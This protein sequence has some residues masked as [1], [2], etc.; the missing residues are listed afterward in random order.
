M[1]AKI[2]FNEN[3]MCQKT[4]LTWNTTA[5]GFEASRDNSGISDNT[6][7]HT[8]PETLYNQKNTPTL[9]LLGVKIYVTTVILPPSMKSEI[10]PFLRNRL[11]LFFI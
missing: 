4:K 5:D 1:K 2:E 3:C 11:L 9:R 8:C 7:Q 6:I 10:E